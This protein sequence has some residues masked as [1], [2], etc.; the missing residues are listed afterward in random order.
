MTSIS[1][2]QLPYALVSAVYAWVKE[3][4]AAK[5]SGLDLESCA[6]SGGLGVVL[7]TSREDWYA[8]ST[9]SSRD[10]RGACGGRRMG[11]KEVT[12]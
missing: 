11:V 9:S 2:L 5:C 10:L 6:R 7:A 1:D 4:V 3:M 12:K 8:C